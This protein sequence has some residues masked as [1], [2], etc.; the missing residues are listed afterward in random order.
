MEKH[1]L[2]Y[3]TKNSCATHFLVFIAEAD[4]CMN[5]VLTKSTRVSI[6]IKGIHVENIRG[7]Y[8]VSSKKE[9]TRE[10]ILDIS[11]PLFAKNGFNSI[12]MKDICEATG[13]S[14][15][16]LYSHFSSTRELFEAILEKLNQ[17]NEMN[18]SVEIE[19]GV[20]AEKILS[21]ALALMED[22][23]NHP[24]DSLSLAMYEYSKSAESG[25]MEQFHKTGQEKWTALIEYG[26][27]RGEFHC[28]NVNEIVPIILYAYQGVRMW[29]RIIT[30]TPE[31]IKSMISYIKK[32]LIKG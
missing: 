4:I 5:K 30:M 7:S 21:N 14:R 25:M 26:I 18:F 3:K 32:Q 29:S 28:V 12:T 2:S 19:Q 16:G 24:Q 23:M 11:Y 22:E 20:P 9:R 8:I 13:L 6:F 15:G 31:T 27:A 1:E 10:L 17:K